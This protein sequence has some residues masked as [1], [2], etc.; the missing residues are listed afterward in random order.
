MKKRTVAALILAALLCLGLLLACQWGALFG[1]RLYVLMYHHFIR[2]GEPYNNWMLTDARLREDLQWLA[3]HG[4]TTVLPS[5]LAAGEPLPEKAVMLTFDDGYESNYTLAYPLLQEFQAKAAIS[6]IVSDIDTQSPGV[7]TWEMCREM[8]QSGL[9]EIGSHT[10]AAHDGEGNGIKRIRGESRKEYEARIFP[11][12]QASIDLIE[13][14]VG[15]AP[16]LFAYPFGVKESWA[17]G[18]L[19]DRFAITLTTRHGPSRI[20]RGLYNLNR[21]NVTMEVPLSEILPD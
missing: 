3:D 18:F 7:L 5:Q 20:A 11:D 10:Y 6:I 8:A 14:H 19:K 17:S 9:V 12:L 21:C 2:E 15:T 4:W 1:P 13:E 16:L